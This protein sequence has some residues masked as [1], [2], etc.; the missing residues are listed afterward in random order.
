MQRLFNRDPGKGNL[1]MGSYMDLYNQP[2]NSRKKHSFYAVKSLAQRNAPGTARTA[3]HWMRSARPRRFEQPL[4][5][6]WCSKRPGM[7]PMGTSGVEQEKLRHGTTWACHVL[8]VPFWGLKQ[9]SE[10]NAIL[11]PIIGVPRRS[12][13]HLFDACVFASS[14]ARRSPTLCRTSLNGAPVPR[15]C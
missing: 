5:R 7:G 12:H 14:G 2:S 15:L 10:R 9:K 1:A 3:G 6:Q 13:P 11:P 8:T 4:V